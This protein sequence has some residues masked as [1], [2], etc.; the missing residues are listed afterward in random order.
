MN[1]QLAP[2]CWDPGA[3][4]IEFGVADGALADELVS[5]GAKYLGVVD[6]ERKIR[7]LASRHPSLAAHLTRCRGRH[8]VRQN[9]ADVLILSGATASHLRTFRDIRHA[10]YVACPLRPT[11]L[12]IWILLFWAWRFLRR[13]LAWPHALQLGNERLIVFRVCRPRPHEAA[14]RFIPHAAGIDGFFRQLRSAGLCC[15]VLRW[16]DS[17]PQMDSGEDLDLLVDDREL[18]AVRK[19]LDSGPGLQPVDLYSVCGSAGADYHG[20]AYYPPM[21]AKQLL[22][23]SVLQDQLF[24]VPSPRDHFLS[25]A[26]HALYHKGDA[27]GVPSGDPRRRRTPPFDHDYRGTLERLALDLKIDA[28]ITL[29]DLDQCLEAAGWRPPE[30]VLHRLARRNRWLSRR[31]KSSIERRSQPVAEALRAA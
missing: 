16:F 27:C 23:R 28:R 14:R 24:P 12:L 26:Y 21:L 20:L 15:V 22:A 8:R 25:L 7:T 31:L 29:D 10:K 5:R 4:I 6:N 17:L 18:A 30:D 9:N 19:L 2:P 11:P 3:R 1:L 13:Q